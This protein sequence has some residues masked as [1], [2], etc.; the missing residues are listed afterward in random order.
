MLCLLQVDMKTRYRL[1]ECLRDLAES[2]GAEGRAVRPGARWRTF[3][4]LGEQVMSESLHRMRH[5]C[6]LACEGGGHGMKSKAQTRVD[7]RLQVC[8]HHSFTN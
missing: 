3:R 8:P 4:C 5:R 7:C 1:H 2:F 6:T